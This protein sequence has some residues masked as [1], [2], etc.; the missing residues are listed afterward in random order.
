M[1]S[2][3]VYGVAIIIFLVLIYFNSIIINKVDKM[4]NYVR[5]FL[6][7]PYSIF[8]TILFGFGVRM[9][10]I[11]LSF[12]WSKE[13]TILNVYSISYIFIP[14]ITSYVF[15]NS[16][17]FMI[18]KYKLIS[19]IVLSVLVISLYIYLFYFSFSNDILIFGDYLLDYFEF[20]RGS[21]GEIIYLI[22]FLTGI[23]FAIKHSI[24]NSSFIGY[25][26]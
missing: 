18:P 5:Y 2:I 9:A 13:D 20:K 4:N 14:M 21:I 12:F 11:I 3:L 25:E 26:D 1:E 23:G 8:V 24:S 17:S 19:S 6:T 10:V 22:S 15:I 16:S 7:I